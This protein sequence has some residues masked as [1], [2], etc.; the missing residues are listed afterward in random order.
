MKKLSQKQWI[1]VAVAVV[2]VALFFIV[3]QFTA[4]TPTPTGQ[5]AQQAMPQVQ[6]TDEVI[7]T[8]AVASAGSTVSVQYVGSFTN[9]TV[10][11]S[12]IPRGTPFSFVVGGGGVIQGFS[13]GVVGMKVGG[14]R[15][16]VIPSELGYGPDAHGPIPGGS[17]L[18][19]EL[20]L[21]SVK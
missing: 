21:I 13:D 19:F 8:G 1:A 15:K 20:Q 17:T 18:V 11:D 9:G 16:V 4:G 5:S 6:I 7:G 10:F 12:S 3:P 14:K 2:I